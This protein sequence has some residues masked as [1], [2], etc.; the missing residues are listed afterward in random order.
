[1]SDI[2]DVEGKLNDD[3]NLEIADGNHAVAGKIMVHKFHSGDDEAFKV[4]GDT[5]I[6]HAALTE[7]EVKKLRRKIDWRI[8]PMLWLILGKSRRICC[9]S[10]LIHSSAQA[11]SMQ[12]KQPWGWLPFSGC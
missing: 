5:H 11:Y 1:M 10:L 3:Q 7:E 6:S 9:G 8:L 12:I 4:L 2:Q